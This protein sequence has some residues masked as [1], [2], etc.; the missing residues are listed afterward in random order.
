MDDIHLFLVHAIQLERDAARGYEE[1]AEAMKTAGN[2]EVAAFFAEMARNSRRH[3][4]AAMARGGFR[5]LPKLSPEEFRWPQGTTPEAAS[6]SGVDGFVPVGTAL[7][8]ALIGEQR[9]FA[10]Y[11]GIA[12]ESNDPEVRQLALEFA[13]E[14]AEHVSQLETLIM[15]RARRPNGVKCA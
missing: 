3:L 9:G 5:E 10:F 4:V 11:A 13:T 1:L 7:A 8:L 2:A 15:R 6:W 14:E 12:A